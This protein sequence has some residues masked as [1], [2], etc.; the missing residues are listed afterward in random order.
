[1]VG[2]GCYEVPFGV[3][4]SFG[5]AYLA[6]GQPQ[7]WVELCRDQLRRGRDTHTISRS[8]LVLALTFA[9]SGDEAMAA[10]GGL[11][12]AAEAIDNPYVLSFALLAYGIAFRDAEP[13]RARDA[14]RR[15]LPIAQESGNRA[16][17]SHLA[18][19]LCQAEGEYGDPLA[20]LEYSTLAIR[21]YHDAGNTI[22]LRSALAV[23]STHLDRLGR[24][25][26]A[27]TIT[28]FALGPLTTAAF[29]EI[30]PAITH[31]RDVLGDHTYQA[32]ARKGESMTDSAIATYAY[33]QIDQA[34]AAAEQLR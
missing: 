13:A 17:E 34:R 4:G 6:V 32:L 9:G 14:L 11:V 3:E 1:V 20:A 2:D 28:G 12:D 18:G 19:V 7:Q 33:D 15:G 26:P 31:L 24:Y 16:N 10:A 25:E 27:A 21:S 8:C 30:N 5:A 22:M 23:L 29:P